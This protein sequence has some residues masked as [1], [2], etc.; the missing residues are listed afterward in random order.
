LKNFLVHFRDLC[1]G[2]TANLTAARGVITQADQLLDFGKRESKGLGLLD[3]ADQLYGI[4]RIFPVTRIP[5][6]RCR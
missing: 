1:R 4:R 3:E 6:P 5:A 2:D